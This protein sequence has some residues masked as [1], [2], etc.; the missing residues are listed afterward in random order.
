MKLKY[1][2]LA[3][4][5]SKFSTHSQHQLGAV[6]VRKTQIVGLGFNQ[7]K[8]HSKSPHPYKSIHAE[9]SAIL[10]SGESDLKNHDI[11]I[12]REKKDGTLGD[13]FPCTVCLK[14]LTDLNIGN[15]F[16]IKNNQFEKHRV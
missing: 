3:K 11:Y 13:S 15:I 2:K 9:F 6:I 4:K 12:Y 16:Y 5:M 1:F 14:M 7:I 8:T 10:N